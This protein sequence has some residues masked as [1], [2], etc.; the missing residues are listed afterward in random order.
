MSAPSPVPASR[1][2]A[3]TVGLEPMHC[4]LLTE[5][6]TREET[7]G[8]LQAVHVETAPEE[9]QAK[10]I[11]GIRGLTPT[12]KAQ[13]RKIFCQE[14]L[15][16]HRTGSQGKQGKPHPTDSVRSDKAG[17]STQSPGLVGQPGRG[18]SHRHSPSPQTTLFNLSH[19]VCPQGR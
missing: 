10:V 11:S 4:C 5:Q 8:G 7:P 17:G 3:W 2:S 6:H 9:M 19:S 15:S 16:E 12:I 1:S 13:S 18:N 14:S